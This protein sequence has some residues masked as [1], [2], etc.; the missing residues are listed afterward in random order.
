MAAPVDMIVRTASP[1]IMPNHTG[2]AES[3]GLS[4][5]VPTGEELK[6]DDAAG[7]KTVAEGA[8]V[9][10]EGAG[11]EAERVVGV[12]VRVIEGAGEGVGV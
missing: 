9:T 1:P 10:G 5:V 4:G 2:L 11:G 8:E 6:T 3:V 12:G 7:L